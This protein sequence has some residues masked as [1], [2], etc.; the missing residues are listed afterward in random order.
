MIRFKN[1]LSEISHLIKTPALLTRTPPEFIL[2]VI[3]AFAICIRGLLFTGVGE[4]PDFF[5][6]VE[7][8]YK[9]IQG[10]FEVSH[11]YQR[12]RFGLIL[13]TALFYWIWEVNEFSSA[14]YPFLC[15]LGSIVLIFYLGKLL[16]DDVA[17]GL[18]CAALLAVFPMEVFYAS[19]AMTEV[20]L[21]FLMALSV[22]LFLK[23]ERISN[24]QYAR[25]YYIGSGI[26]AGLAYMTK[27]FAVFLALFLLCYILYKRK[28]A[29]AYFWMT[30]G[31][32]CV[33]LS[34]IAFYYL[35]TGNPLYRIATITLSLGSGV[36][37]NP[38]GIYS[39]RFFLYPYYWFVSL[40]HF[41]FFY[42]CIIFAFLYSLWN[43]VK[44]TYIPMLWAGSLFLYL[45][46]GL[47]G[48][49]LTP[50]HKEARFLSIITIPCLLVLGY[51]LTKISKRRKRLILWIAISFLC[52]TSLIFISFHRTL[53]RSEVENLRAIARYAQQLPGDTVMY[54][55]NQSTPYVHYFLGYR[56]LDRIRPFN[57]FNATTGENSY[58]VDLT[59][60]DRA[61]VVV[62]WRTI[63]GALYTR[64]K[65]PEIISDH[66]SYWEVAHTIQPSDNW[67][68]ATVR[69][70]SDSALIHYL[71]ER[72]AQKILKTADR[73]LKSSKEKTIIYRIKQ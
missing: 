20:P 49:H 23:G 34:E 50:I 8:A 71:P 4:M 7:P 31:F 24:K 10:T 6:H 43:K 32:C 35:Q 14:L 30:L 12:L 38:G 69:I 17:S 22:Y 46:F 68:Y 58:P 45:Q 47:E 61:Y 52:L 59:R 16:F 39:S 18:V 11:S 56:M 15:S 66:P 28:L 60:L 3:L 27:I 53:Q 2:L 57:T 13:P 51:V 63:K 48:R 21:S 26:I 1:A 55:D 72:A 41:G 73:T 64:V 62:N 25:W 29:T 44:E 9:I 36:E 5:S 54:L 70:L 42:Y 40:H 37:P 65:F 33:L 67:V 19:Q